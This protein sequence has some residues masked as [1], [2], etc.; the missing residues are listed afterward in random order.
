MRVAVFAVFLFFSACL[1]R[2]Q[3]NYE[4]PLEALSSTI[5]SAILEPA[6]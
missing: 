1:S 4:N 6:E 5:S 3:T 2:A